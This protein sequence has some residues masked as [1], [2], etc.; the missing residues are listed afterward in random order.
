M[1]FSELTTVACFNVTTGDVEDAP[2]LDALAKYD[3]VEKDG[4]VFVTADE[5]GLKSNFPSTLSL[6]CQ[7]QGAEKIVVVGGWVCLLLSF[8]T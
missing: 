3:V 8:Q 1:A 6:K 2:A 7:A 5:A 4:G